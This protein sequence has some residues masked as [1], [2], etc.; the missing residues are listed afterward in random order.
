MFTRCDC[1]CD[2]FFTTNGLYGIFSVIVVIVLCEHL[3]PVYTERQRQCC[4]DTCNS[5]LTENNRVTP[6][7][8]CNS[9]SSDSTVFNENSFTSVIATLT[10]TIGVNGP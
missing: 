7:W 10:L 2:L 8:V 4:D 5:V 3:G 6:D 9:F 1:E